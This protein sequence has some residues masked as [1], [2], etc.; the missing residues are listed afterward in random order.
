MTALALQP[1]S[2]V[3]DAPAA[4]TSASTAAVSS[5]PETSAAMVGTPTYL[6]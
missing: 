1:H 2:V 6:G 5:M 4:A 3:S